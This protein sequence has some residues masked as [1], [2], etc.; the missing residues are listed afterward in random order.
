MGF[1][2]KRMKQITLFVLTMAFICISS[3]ADTNFAKSEAG[4]TTHAQD[5]WAEDAQSK[6]S[7]DIGDNVSSL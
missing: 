6:A 1:M 3:A 7:S 4:S 2:S 5:Q